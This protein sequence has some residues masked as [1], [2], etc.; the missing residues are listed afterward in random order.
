ME[1]LYI[2]N[3]DERTTESLLTGYFSQ[4]GKVKKCII[5]KF[6]NGLCKGF[7]KLTLKDQKTYNKIMDYEPGHIILGRKINLEPFIE[8]SKIMEQKLAE[9][10]T[11]KICILGIPKFLKEKDLKK[12]FNEYGS[13][14][15]AYLRISNKKT[16]NFGFIIFD[17]A[18]TAE[19]VT[20]N[21]SL[22]I[23]NYDV[24]LAIK[25]FRSNKEYKKQQKESNSDYEEEIEDFHKAASFKK[26]GKF[27]EIRNIG[28]LKNNFFTAQYNKNNQYNKKKYQKKSNDHLMDNKKIQI[29]KKPLDAVIEQFGINFMGKL[30]LKI[31]IKKILEV[32]KH[33]KW[34]EPESI[35][36]LELFYSNKLNSRKNLIGSKIARQMSLDVN[37]NHDPTNV[38][39]NK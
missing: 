34:I 32:N 16:T 9:L 22:Y 12:I 19:Y 7:A 10:E 29:Y 5:Y 13:V 2:S 28:P 27:S 37:F 30:R 17:H 38:I 8:N 14:E 39:L 11:R 36:K 6:K 1:S 25:K 31:Y 18:E 3:L 26:K 33:I 20:Q 35:P 24:T 4:F 21:K 15:K 23:E